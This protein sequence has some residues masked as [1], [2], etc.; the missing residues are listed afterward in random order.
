MVS[1]ALFKDTLREVRRSFGRYISILIITMLGVAFF[2]G[3]RAAGPDME[4]TADL[5]YDAQRLMDVRLVSTFGFDEQDVAAVRAESCVESLMPA[6]SLDVLVAHG[7]KSSVVKLHSLG[8][9]KDA[10]NQPVLV[11]GRLPE[12]TGEC[13]VL[14]EELLGE[15]MGVGEQLHFYLEGEDAPALK[16]QDFT[17][18]GMVATPYY[19]SFERGTS[20]LGTGKVENVVYILEDD[21]DLEVYTDLYV[22]LQDAR[23]LN[24]FS[25][26]YAALSDR[27]V[28]ALEA[29][30]DAQSVRRYDEIVAEA[31]EKISDGRLQLRDAQDEFDEEISNAER[32]IAD[33]A[34]ELEE[35]EQALADAQTDT[36]AQLATTWRK[37][38]SAK[39]ALDAGWA[40]YD[41]NA[42]QLAAGE[43]AFADAQA[44]LST[45]TTELAALEV[46]LAA[47]RESIASGAL[48]EEQLSQAQTQLAEG[49]QQLAAGR[50][51]LAAAQTELAAQRAA[52]DATTTI[53]AQAKAELETGQA[54][55][56]KGLSSYYT[57][58]RRAKEELADA[59]Q[60]IEDGKTELA[61][62]QNELADAKIEGAQKIADAQAELADAEQQL[63]E[64]ELPEWY[65]LDRTQHL[66]HSDYADAADRMDALAQVFPSLFF[67]IAAFVCLNTMARMVDEQRTLIGTLKALGYSRAAVAG[68]YLLY[69]A[70]ASVVGSIAGIFVGIRL[71]PA[72][73]FNAYGIMYNLPTLQ[74]AFYPGTAVTSA[75]IAVAVTV[76]AA[77]FSCRRELRSVPAEL[78]RPKA[79][80]AGKRVWLEYIKPLW[81]HMSFTKKVTAR[82]LFRYKK[83]FLMTVLGIAG[84]TALLLAGFGLQ[85]SIE[86]IV[87]YQFDDLDAYSVMVGISGKADGADQSVRAVTGAQD[88]LRA[89][90]KTMDF[91]YGEERMSATMTVFPAVDRVEN[92]ITLRDRVS[93]QAIQMQEEGVVLT[94]KLAR[95]LGVQV[96]ETIELCENVNRYA[97]TVTGVTENYAGHYCYMTQAQYEALFGEP[98]TYNLIYACLGQ[99]DEEQRD[100]WSKALLKEENIASV[101]F[102]EDLR[103]A[104]EEALD[105]LNVVVMVL[106]LSAAALALLILYNL[107]NINVSERF[108]E[109]ATIKVLGFYDGEVLSYVYR[110]N[111]LLTGIGI[112]IGCFLGVALHA[113]LITTVE[114]S[115]VMFGRSIDPISFV[116]SCLFVIAFAL[117]VNFVM[118]F[119]L[120]RIDM[121]EA[122]KT[123]E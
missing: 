30:A 66:S 123:V 117:L 37:L 3:L 79:P 56:D 67:I 110:E 114:V 54:E 72:V 71:F 76:L 32:E 39:A 74:F 95:T 107:T 7:E 97:V 21:F 12:Q 100:A 83:R 75:A 84:S 18:V 111:F 1:K 68:K 11:E 105:A 33:A 15:S 73:V 77:W 65:L 99:A 64:L 78:M 23:K 40:E 47:L 52:L 101:T 10:L 44:Q 93:G 122:L 119:K 108:R 118:F 9:G 13:V 61:D 60:R 38:K 5:Y 42:A 48:S 19:M 31:N 89:Y 43:Q 69:A 58:R 82:N 6:Y 116:W 36:D 109:I 80:P 50:Q 16:T 103:N 87:N 91:V 25:D 120:R 106:I 14:Q 115:A 59:A 51:M 104:L 86:N 55:Y 20:T 35:G 34:Q 121:V 62:A 26:A 17:V 8:T 28:E 88:T 63:A 45:Q 29:V 24:T 94:E 85:D 41:G 46:R 4:L 22:T 102:I 113:Y 53:L 27:A 92:Y 49:E 98:V 57:A 112:L 2:A 96:G 81:K 70:S 90:S